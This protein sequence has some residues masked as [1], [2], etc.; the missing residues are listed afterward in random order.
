M[1][2]ATIVARFDLE[3]FDTVWERDVQYTRDCFLG[4]SGLSSRG[5][6]VKVLADNKGR[7]FKEKEPEAQFMS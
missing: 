4:E 1:A 2:L 5:V 3:L 7:L 6:R